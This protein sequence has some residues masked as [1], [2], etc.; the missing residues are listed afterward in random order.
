MNLAEVSHPRLG[1][2]YTIL[3]A[4]DTV[5]LV[6]GEDFRYT[7]TGPGLDRWLPE[8]LGRCD[9]RCSL[10]QLLAGLEETVRPTAREV[11]E[12]LHGERVLVN[13]TPSEAHVPRRY[14][15]AVEGAG[16]LVDVLGNRSETSGDSA[17]SLPI[18]VQDQ[19]DYE[20]A[21]CFNRRCLRGSS[22]WL[23]ASTGP[24]NRGYVSPPFLPG[25]GP[26]LACLL[27]HFQRL[28]PAPEL[29]DA[30]AEHVRQGGAIV[31]VPFPEG[32]VEVLVQLV[33]WKVDQLVQEQPPATLYRLH[34]LEI[35]NMEVSTHCVFADPECPECSDAG[36]AP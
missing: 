11:L 13:G 9:G 5:R 26:C 20:T 33:L 30:L 16:P 18:L 12:R 19:L 22:P 31:P 8:F 21:L 1:L 3:T 32:A 7:I 25:A 17:L 6:A 35:E 4:A 2:P 23:W 34:V 28:S 36:L 29:Y 14:R 15:L 10:D 24:M 27:R